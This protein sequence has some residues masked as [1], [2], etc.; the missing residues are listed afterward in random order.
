MENTTK[1]QVD[2]NAHQGVLMNSWDIIDCFAEQLEDTSSRHSLFLWGKTGAG[3]SALP[4]QIVNKIQKRD[5]FTKPET[6]ITGQLPN[7]DVY[8]K[9]GVVDTRLNSLESVDIRGLPQCD[10]NLTRWIPPEELPIMGQEDRFP[11]KGI[12]LL[13]EFTHA[14]YSVQNCGYQ[15]TLDYKVGT[16]TVLPGWTVIAASNLSTELTHSQ[17]MAKPL[18]NRFMHYQLKLSLEAFKKWGFLNNVDPWIISFLNLHPEYLHKETVEEEHAFPTPRS[19]VTNSD[20]IQN[21]ESKFLLQKVESCVGIAAA[22]KFEA[23]IDIFL[24]KEN[25]PRYNEISQLEQILKG[26]NKAPKPLGLNEGHIAHAILSRLYAIVQKNPGDMMLP[27]LQFILSDFWKNSREYSRVGLIDLKA[28]NYDILL[29]I[30]EKN[31]NKNQEISSLLKD[32]A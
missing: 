26:K 30:V 32:F 15:I 9:W 12:W 19:W 13:D 1:T 23:F 8:D 10:Q 3:K 7:L 16:H 14:D 6:P 17:E 25:N 28:I 22:S 20:V 24:N 11:D 29:E 27:A 4:P 21:K 2:E 18:R 5:L 31:A